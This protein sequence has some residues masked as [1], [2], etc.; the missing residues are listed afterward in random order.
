MNT[1]F[2]NFQYQRSSC[3]SLGMKKVLVC[4]Q[5]LQVSETSVKLARHCPISDRGNGDY[6]LERWKKTHSCSTC[7][8]SGICN[9]E[10]LFK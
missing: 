8:L 7:A 4:K 2:S 5:I 10:E 3:G 1:R 6:A 9:C